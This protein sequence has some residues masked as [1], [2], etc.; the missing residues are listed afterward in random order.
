MKV[1]NAFEIKLLN[2]GNSYHRI[3]CVQ[4]IT[5][6][7]PVYGKVALGNRTPRA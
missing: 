2:Q 3:L 1:N 7:K 5:Q 6:T 4:G